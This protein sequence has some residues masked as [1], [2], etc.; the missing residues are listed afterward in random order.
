MSCQKVEE[1]MLDYIEGT[2]LLEELVAFRSHLES[3]ATCQNALLLQQEIVQQFDL[4]TK[5]IEIPHDFMVQVE[6]KINQPSK[7]RTWKPIGLRFGIVAAILALVLI[8]TDLTTGILSN[9][10]AWWQ[11]VG[12]TEQARGYRIIGEEVNITAIDQDIRIT[13]THVAADEFGTVLYYEVEDLKKQGLYSLQSVDFDGW[14]KPGWNS[15]M[16]IPDPKLV[17]PTE[18]LGENNDFYVFREFEYSDEPYVVKGWATLPPLEQD[19]TTIPIR[20]EDINKVTFDTAS[21]FIKKPNLEELFAVMGAWNLEVPITKRETKEYKINQNVEVDG[22]EVT[23]QSLKLSPTTSILQYYYQDLNPN[24]EINIER[25]EANGKSFWVNNRHINN[26]T[27]Y[28]G[29]P[30]VRFHTIHYESMYYEEPEEFKIHFGT[31]SRTMKSSEEFPIHIDQPFPQTFEFLGSKI[32]INNVDIGNRTK[33]EID[34]EDDPDRIFDSLIFSFS[35]NLGQRNQ[36]L[37][38]FGYQPNKQYYVD[39]NGHRYDWGNY[40]RPDT[41]FTVR[42]M[43]GNYQYSLVA[44]DEQQEIIPSVIRIVSYEQTKFLNDIITIKLK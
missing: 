36:N 12:G 15:R 8:T 9:F 42:T 25:L 34:L 6:T 32:S 11:N 24:I 35:T 44:F 30:T 43:D 7:K 4:E 13:I 38:G 5:R 26:A 1:Q 29:S 2:L 14:M 3:C 31:I 37:D 18:W 20:I 28:S 40:Y 33:L 19:S 27:Q 21:P 10:A 16:K 17:W 41:P 23:I 22:V 39:R